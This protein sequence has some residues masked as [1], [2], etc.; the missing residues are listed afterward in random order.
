MTANLLDQK[1]T[2]GV[3]SECLVNVIGRADPEATTSEPA[4]TINL[5]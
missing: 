3:S 4:L 2:L 1:V 5:V